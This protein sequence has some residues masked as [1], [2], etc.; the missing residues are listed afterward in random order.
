MFQLITDNVRYFTV[1]SKRPYA[2][3]SAVTKSRGQ[4]L[5]KTEFAPRSCGQQD[6]GLHTVHPT[7][8][9]DTTTSSQTVVRGGKADSKPR[10]FLLPAFAVLPLLYLIPLQQFLLFEKNNLKYSTKEPRKKKNL[11]RDFYFKHTD[12]QQIDFQNKT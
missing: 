5:L 1:P 11:F 4:R 8:H 6:G 3:L 10:L 2:T 12:M 7:L 9:K